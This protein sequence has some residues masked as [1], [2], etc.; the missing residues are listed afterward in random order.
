MGT[1][2]GAILAGPDIVPASSS[3]GAAGL[4]PLRST[5]GLNLVPFSILPHDEHDERRGAN[6]E[7]VAVHPQMRFVKSANDV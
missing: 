5:S 7:I 1:S 2:V 3:T 6:D 4:P